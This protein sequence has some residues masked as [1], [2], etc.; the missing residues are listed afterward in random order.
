MKKILTLL[1]LGG[2]CF[3]VM[4]SLYG[5]DLKLDMSEI[6]SRNSVAYV[7]KNVTGDNDGGVIFGESKNL[8]DGSANMV[9]SIVVNYR[10]FDTLGEVT[11]L[12]VASL[13]VA[14]LLGLSDD[15]K[16]LS[17]LRK[18]LK[19]MKAMDLVKRVPWI[20]SYPNCLSSVSQTSCY[21]VDHEC[22]LA[23]SYF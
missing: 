9:S 19:K 5:D 12:F 10:S 21:A 3:M 6:R 7:E 23:S 22:S 16:K 2:I 20:Q 1:L 8:E 13:G 15:K 17:K 18:T 4:Q 11:V 14:F